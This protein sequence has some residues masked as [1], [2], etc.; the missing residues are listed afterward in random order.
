MS[1]SSSYSVPLTS[2][3]KVNMVLHVFSK[4]FIRQVPRKVYGDWFEFGHVNCISTL[5]V[6]VVTLGRNLT[7]PHT[8]Q[9]T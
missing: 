3:I 9:G 4:L 5:R 1:E 7:N 2:V 8:L 6:K